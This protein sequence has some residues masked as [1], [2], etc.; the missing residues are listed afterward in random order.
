M[1]VI[2]QVL[3]LKYTTLGDCN[4]PGYQIKET[5]L[6]MERTAGCSNLDPFRY[7]GL[8]RPSQ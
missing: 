4:V 1:Q 7:L 6:L 8:P 2:Y 5:K 3:Y